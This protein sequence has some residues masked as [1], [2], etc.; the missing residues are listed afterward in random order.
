MSRNQS[1]CN[2]F[3]NTFNDPAR[4]WDRLAS[5][6][7]IYAWIEEHRQSQASIYRA[8]LRVNEPAS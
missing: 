6:K 8:T 7:R 4:Q 2:E 3:T 5:A 1:L